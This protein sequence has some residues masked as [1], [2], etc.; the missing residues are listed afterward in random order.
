MSHAIERIVVFFESLTP[1]SL[2]RISEF[3]TENAYFKDP[4]NEV[5]GASDVQRI[6]EHM[7][8]ALDDPSFVI[9]ARVVERDQCFLSWD[10]HFRFRKF[11]PRVRQTIRGTTHL[12]L[13]AD[14]RIRYHRDYW[15][16]AEELY[17][18]LPMIGGLMRWLKRRARS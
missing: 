2:G 1:R 6:F 7:Y 14:G 15:D 16:A 8:V 12:K 18:K 13:A 3:Y 17:E 10:F 4:F 9:T 11:H 5:R